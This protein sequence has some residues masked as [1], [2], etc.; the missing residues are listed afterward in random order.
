MHAKQCKN[1]AKTSGVVLEA[2]RSSS[3]GICATLII[4]NGILKKGQTIL[5]GTEISGMRIAEDFTGK[6]IS[7]AGCGRAILVCGW[8][9]LP[10]AGETFVVYE[11][12]KEAEEAAAR[13]SQNT[14][15]REHKNTKQE[16]GAAVIIPIVIKADTLGSIEALKHETER[17]ESDKVK[18]KIAS[19]GLGDVGENDMRLAESIKNSI[20]VGFNVEADSPARKRS[21]QS[22]SRKIHIFDI[23]YRL[24]EFLE[25][26]IKKQTPK[27]TKEE[28]ARQARILKI[29]SETKQAQVV[30]GKVLA[31]TITLGNEFRIVRRGERIGT[32]KIKELQKM[33]E[34]IREAAEGAEFGALA[35][36]S[37]P[38]AVGDIIEVTKI[39]EV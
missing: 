22:G 19:A 26:E 33:K 17:L 39:V 8:S 27:E 32:G 30:G 18:I 29:F 34:K 10:R 5:A 36:P 13:S 14:K 4:K 11:N 12:K 9:G 35:A 7:E 15:A 38:L 6:P 20:V 3:K 31:G 25:D 24:T 1:S 2:H 16:E 23:I 21:Q 28:I 37:I